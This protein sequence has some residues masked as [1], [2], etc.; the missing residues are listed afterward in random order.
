MTDAYFIESGLDAEDYLAFPDDT[1]TEGLPVEKYDESM[2][3]GEGGDGSVDGG[4]AV[5]YSVGIGG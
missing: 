5:G 4:F 1:L 2:F 3:A